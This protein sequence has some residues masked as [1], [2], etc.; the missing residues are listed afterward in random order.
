MKKTED[1]YMLSMAHAYRHGSLPPAL[2]LT[3]EELARRIGTYSSSDLERFNQEINED[4]LAT[5]EFPFHVLGFTS[6][7]KVAYYGVNHIGA[8]PLDK[9]RTCL[10]KLIIEGA[11]DKDKLIALTA[12]M[13][14][15]AILAQ[16]N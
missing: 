5:C 9:L 10:D 15:E 2:K 1:N 3:A 16:N 4:M 7:N 12:K 11:E 14:L 8:M 6:D 13:E